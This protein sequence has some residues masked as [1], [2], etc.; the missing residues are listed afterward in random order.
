M[1]AIKGLL[2]KISI[3]YKKRKRIPWKTGYSAWISLPD[4]GKEKFGQAME[5]SPEWISEFR[6]S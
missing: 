2:V 4:A 3:R 6:T 1:Q 5:Q